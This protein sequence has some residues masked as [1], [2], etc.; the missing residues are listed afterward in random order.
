MKKIVFLSITALFFLFSF[1]KAM[2]HD[3][4]PVIKACIFEYDTAK[5]NAQ[6]IE[7]NQL[8]KQL[9]VIKKTGRNELQNKGFQVYG[10]NEINPDFCDLD[11]LDPYYAFTFG[12]CLGPIGVAMVFV[13]ENGDTGDV[14]LSIVGC[15]IPTSLLITYTILEGV[16]WN[17]Y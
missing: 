12:C 4:L 15:L 14:T 3:S 6:F 11:G 13:A 16:W 17:W 8:E 10:Y 1:A 9:A 5:I 7:L 2:P